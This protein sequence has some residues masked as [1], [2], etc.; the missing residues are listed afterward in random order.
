MSLLEKASILIT[1][2][3]YDVGSINAIKPKDS[4]FADLD[5]TRATSGS[6][7][8][9]ANREN[10]NGVF[11]EVAQN[12]PRIDY[13]GGTGHWLFEPQATNT[14]TY[15]NDFTQGSL[16]S[17]GSG[18]GIDNAVLTSAQATSP[19][20]NNNAWKLADNNDGNSGAVALRYFGTNVISGNYNV[21]SLFV[22][23]QGNNDW[24]QIAVTEFDFTSA[25][26]YFDIS[27]GELGTISSNFTDANIEDYGDGWYRI[28]VAF[29]TTTDTQGAIQFRLAEADQNISITRNGTNGA[30]IYGIQCES[31]VDDHKKK[32]TSYIPTSGSTVTKAEDFANNSGNSDLISSTEGVL[33][34]EVAGLNS[35]NNFE[36]IALS[37]GNNDTRVRLILKEN[38]NEVAMQVNNGSATSEVFINHTLS[39]VT[40]F[41]KIAIKYKQNDFAF[42]I[43]GVEVDDDTLGT[44]PTLD[45]LTLTSGASSNKFYGK[46]KCSKKH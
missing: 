40:D 42:W 32:P 17:G 13:L 10:A 3:A 16:F 24:F 22:K 2:T 20:G 14:A 23:K 38:I 1:P 15:S 36:S 21:V 5:F 46:I 6:V 28:S 37:D 41:N 30:F 43:N 45:R 26:A 19:D 29:T 27:N 7:V 31:T 39:D 35:T 18:A 4:P 44:V 25:T 8:G 34:L 11:E 12:L 9:T 33:Y